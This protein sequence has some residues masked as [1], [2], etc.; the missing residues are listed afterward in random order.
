MQRSNSRYLLAFCLVLA[1][2][3]TS[4]FA[5]EHRSEFHH[6]S[7]RHEADYVGRIDGAAYQQPFGAPFSFGAGPSQQGWQPGFNY[8]SPSGESADRSSAYQGLVAE[9]ASANG[10]PS[11]LVERVITR[12]RRYNPRAVSRG[13]YGLMQIRLGTARAMGYGGSAAGLLDP[14]TN[15]TYAVR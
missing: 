13:N 5:H 3:A 1:L 9:Q 12:E 7:Y 2:A 6:L 11:S 4:A 8:V 14:T 15:M 10:V